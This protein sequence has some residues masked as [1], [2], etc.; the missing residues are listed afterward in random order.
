ME[1][2]DLRGKLSESG[3]HRH[4]GGRFVG[5]DDENVYFG[6]RGWRRISLH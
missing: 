1:P 4:F 2:L 5:E 3:G 6:L